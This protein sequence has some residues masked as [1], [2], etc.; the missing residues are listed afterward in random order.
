MPHKW[1]LTFFSSVLNSM[2]QQPCAYSKSV[3]LLED[4]KT[5]LLG[6]PTLHCI[7]LFQLLAQVAY[8]HKSILKDQMD[9][10]KS[11]GFGNIFL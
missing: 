5:E 1:Y 4:S 3:V 2:H 7:K 10:Q 6:E 8:V 9:E 11:S